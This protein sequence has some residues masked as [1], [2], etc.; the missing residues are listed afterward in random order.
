VMLSQ[1][2]SAKGLR[3]RGQ[4]GIASTAVVPVSGSD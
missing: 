2:H 4:S 3:Q 1:M